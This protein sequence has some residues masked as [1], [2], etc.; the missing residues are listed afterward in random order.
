ML[1]Q[2]PGERERQPTR[3]T[4]E[5]PDVVAPDLETG[6]PNACEPERDMEQGEIPD[7]LNQEVEENENE[8]SQATRRSTF[9]R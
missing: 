3:E 4:S 1:Q 8:E 7:I 6:N 2:Q 9:L 5:I